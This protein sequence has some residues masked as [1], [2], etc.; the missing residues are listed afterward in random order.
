MATTRRGRP[1]RARPG[2]LTPHAPRQPRP[3]HAPSGLHRACAHPCRSALCTPRLR[4]GA[5]SR[6]S[7]T[8]LAAEP[9]RERVDAQPVSLVPRGPPYQTFHVYPRCPTPTGTAPC[10]LEWLKCHRLSVTATC[11]RCISHPLLS[12]NAQFP[13]CHR[14]ADHACRHKCHR[15]LPP[16]TTVP[17]C[18]RF[19]LQVGEQ[20]RWRGAPT[21][22]RGCSSEPPLWRVSPRLEVCGRS[23]G[24]RR[25]AD[26]CGYCLRTQD[27]ADSRVWVRGAEVVWVRV[28]EDTVSIARQCIPFVT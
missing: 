19:V 24:V 4:L 2:L 1:I 7:P 15:T 18:G 21:P 10:P 13:P 27:G 3:V 25:A 8:T 12:T 16:A 14:R 23:R 28:S 17:S 9:D 5:R 20:S 22:R 11:L 26:V 6:S